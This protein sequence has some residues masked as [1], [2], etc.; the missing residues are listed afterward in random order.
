MHDILR[1]IIDSE[2]HYPIPDLTTYVPVLSKLNDKRLQPRHGF[3]QD[4]FTPALLRKTCHQEILTHYIVKN[5]FLPNISTSITRNSH[6]QKVTR[7][8]SERF[9]IRECFTTV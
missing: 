9:S 8:P 3:L 6:L 5:L 7:R 2:I 4:S 1:L